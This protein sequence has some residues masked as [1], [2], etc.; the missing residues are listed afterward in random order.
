MT[1]ILAGAVFAL[2]YARGLTQM[3]PLPDPPQGKP[4]PNPPQGEGEAS[5]M[6]SPSPA[7]PVGRVRLT[8]WELAEFR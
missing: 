5:A 7:L 1:Q 8:R 4:L 3:E 6:G 2:A